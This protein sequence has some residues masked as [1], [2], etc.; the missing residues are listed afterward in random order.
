MVELVELYQPSTITVRV[1]TILTS[2]VSL[3]L[4]IFKI[5]LFQIQSVALRD[6]LLQYFQNLISWIFPAIHIPSQIGSI[7]FLWFIANYSFH[8]I[9]PC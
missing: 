4:N 2:S 8:P 9:Q 3:V 6:I 7:A 1:P 5:L